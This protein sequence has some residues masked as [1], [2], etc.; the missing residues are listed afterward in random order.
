MAIDSLRQPCPACFRSTVLISHWWGRQWTHV[1]TWRPGCEPAG[2]DR[3][4]FHSPAPD[5]RPPSS[6]L[7]A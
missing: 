6:D 3:E 5:T 7:A 2:R 4:A 1:G